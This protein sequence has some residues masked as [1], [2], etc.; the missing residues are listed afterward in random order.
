LSSTTIDL[1]RHGETIN[2]SGFRGSI[3]DALTKEGEQQMWQAV[4]KAPHQWDQIISSPLQ[5]CAF[6]ARKF[7]QQHALPLTLE[8]RLKEMHFGLWEGQTATVLMERD[9]DALSKFWQDPLANTPPE[10]EPLRDFEQRI[11]SAWQE[12][13]ARYEGKKIL[14]VTH[15]GV[16]RL[17]L[18]HILQ[19]SVNHLLEFEV[20]HAAIERIVITDKQARR[21]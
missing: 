18:C 11:L 13:T 20:K 4:E 7:S 21:L 14:L 9:A 12:I 5:R 6:F 2:G 3:D 10:A 16:I 8:A 17:L 19:R 15:G 1:F